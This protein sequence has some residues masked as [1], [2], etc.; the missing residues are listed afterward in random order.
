V[1]RESFIEIFDGIEEK[2][3][4]PY[5]VSRYYASLAENSDPDNDPIAAQYIPRSAESIHLD[6]ESPDPLADEQY[7]VAPR[8][9]HHYSDRILILVN[10]RC[11]TYCRHCFRR[12]FTG[13]STGRITPDE[14]ELAAEYL[15]K[16]P[17]VEEV[18]LSG[19]DPLM[20][21]DE[22]LFRII[23]SCVMP[24]ASGS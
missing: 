3:R 1:S 9:I 8:V 22:E 16:N 6:Y 15:N 23:G 4:L 19:G 2:T 14:L 20:L 21:S 13:S 12:H 17:A 11:A 5:G 10:D 18:L 24:P 7:S